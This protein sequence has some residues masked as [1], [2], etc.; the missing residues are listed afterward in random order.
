MNDVL[1][2]PYTEADVRRALFDMHPSKAPGPDGFTALFFQKNWQVVGH[3]VTV[4]ALQ[5]LNVQADP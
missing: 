3:E 2:A 4:A 5:I 1:C